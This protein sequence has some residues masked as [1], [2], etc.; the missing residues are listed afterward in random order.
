MTGAPKHGTILVLVMSLGTHD[1]VGD[2]IA[3]LAVELQKRSFRP[4]IIIRNPV[5]EKNPYVKF[6][7]AHRVSVWTV[8]QACLSWARRICRLVQIA[9]W[10][11]ILCRAVIRGQTTVASQRSAWG[12]LRRFGYSGLDVLLVQRLVAAKIVFRTRI[13]HFR[14]PDSW[15]ALAWVKLLGMTTIYTEDVVPRADTIHYYESLSENQARIDCITAVSQASANA[16]QPYFGDTRLIHV[17]PNMV[18]NNPHFVILP[19]AADNA[20]RVAVLARLSPQKDLGTFLR[21]CAIA[22]QEDPGIEFTVFG[23]GPE[24]RHLLA[25]RT[26]LNLNST[27]L[28]AGAFAK[29]ELSE[30]MTRI[31]AVVLSSVYEGMP[32]SLL[33]AMAFGKP[34]VATAV[35][36]VPE[37][38]KDG[39]TGIL[40]PVR[41]PE[42]LA[43][44]ILALDRDKELYSRMAHAARERYLACFT[45][46]QVVPQYVALYERLA[47]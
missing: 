1:G 10:P 19:P 29:A 15:P 40:V 36:G 9:L 16:L 33:E 17:I 21:A 28:F 44:A 2:Q 46:D 42:A 27:V 35:D 47:A 34:V 41:D 18:G 32:V 20:L 45:P 4:I 39:V 31:D 25:L 26:Q 5:S 24:Y 8:S 38:V 13:A 23:D 7:R 11:V 22:H 6:M 3:S 37:V 43:A 12:L 30:I 14:K